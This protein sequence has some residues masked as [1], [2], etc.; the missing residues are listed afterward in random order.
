MKRTIARQAAGRD[1]I[2]KVA[3]KRF[4]QFGFRRTSVAE[5]AREAGVA[6]GTLYWHF[7]S[8]EDLFLH[9]IEEDNA[10]WLA[11][12][13]EILD[14]PGAPAERLAELG[15]ASVAFYQES[16]LLFA[17]L[18]RD[19]D[20]VFAPLLDDIHARLLDQN[21][22]M[23]AEV[24][25]EGVVDGTMRPVDPEQ[26]AYILFAVGHCLFNQT[27]H[28]YEELAPLLGDMAL[29]GL[30]ARGLRTDPAA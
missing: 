24:I 25:R 8:K 14:G 23:M 1:R 3:R 5:I 27:D 15:I 22:S 13:R 12:A 16:K 2:L 29:Q 18:R 28:P 6:T 4:E 19:R 30:L 26:A 9:I 17:V 21:V 10:E 20:I 11:R 7:E